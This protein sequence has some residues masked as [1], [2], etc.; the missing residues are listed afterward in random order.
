MTKKRKVKSFRDSGQC[1]L[2]KAWPS[3]TR[4]A[5]SHVP[6]MSRTHFFYSIVTFMMMIIRIF[7]KNLAHKNIYVPKTFS[8]I[9]LKSF[10]QIF[11]VLQFFLKN[12]DHCRKSLD[13]YMQIPELENVKSFTRTNINKPDFTPRKSR[14]FW[15]FKPTKQ[16]LWG[17]L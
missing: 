10:A 14:H 3:V 4:A 9:F 11:A 16:N 6:V 8:A 17:F 5:G 13:I 15:H 2:G 7:F 12:V 1:L